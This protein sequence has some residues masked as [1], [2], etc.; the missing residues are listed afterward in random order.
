MK[1]ES[2][3]NERDERLTQSVGDSLSRAASATLRSASIGE[4]E[5]NPG[6]SALIHFSLGHVG[7]P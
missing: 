3:G 7:A 1:A 2:A 5:L 6:A 4:L